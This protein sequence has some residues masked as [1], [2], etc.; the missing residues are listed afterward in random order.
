MAAALPRPSKCPAK[1][2]K[3]SGSNAWS[4]VSKRQLVALLFSFLTVT[5][6]A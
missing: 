2:P 6:T 4:G 3:R 5:K 1:T